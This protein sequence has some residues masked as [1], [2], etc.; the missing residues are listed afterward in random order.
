MSTATSADVRAP[1][2]PTISIRDRVRAVRGG[3]AWVPAPELLA[4]LVVAAVLDLWALDRN[5]WANTYYSATVRSMA[6]SWHNFFYNSF[7]ASGVMTVDKPPLALWVQA[8]SARAFGFSSWSMLVPQALMGV[9]T[10]ALAYDL[11]RRVFGRPA[12]F[13]AG[14]VLALTPITVAISRHN[15]PDALVVLCSTAALWFTVRALLDGRTSRLVWAGVMVGL[16]F[17]TKMGAALL[18]LPALAAA[19]LWVAPRGRLTAVRQL[20]TG[21]AAMAVVGLAWPVLMWLTPASSRPWISGTS[22]NSIWS[23]IL[24]YNGVGRLDGQ[25]GGPGGTAGGPGGG[26]GGGMGSVFGG[27]TGITRLVDASLGGQAGWLLGM[28]LAGGLAVAVLTRLRRGDARTGW[29]IAAGGAFL[30]TA[31]AF[32]YA[33]GIF[34]PYYVSML[35]PF[36]AVLI[37]ATAGTI[38]KAGITARIIAPVAIVGGLVTEVMVIHRGAADVE[39]LVPLAI[40]AGLGGAA[41]LAAQ[42]PAKVRGVAL[43]VAL[44]ALLI[45][46]ASWA[47]QT[48]GHATSSTFPA[49][50]PASQGM[51]G[52]GPGGMRGGPGGGGGVGGPG[53]GAPPQ[54]PGGTGSSSSGQVAPPAGFSLGGGSNTSNNAQGAGGPGA[55]GGGGMF[56][57]NANLTEALAYAKA[58]GG[59]TI[60]VSSQQGA[61]DAIIRSGSDV[62]ALGGFS[63]RESEVSATWLAQA[64]KDGRIR[65]VLTDGSGGGMGNDDRVGSSALMAVVQQ[66]GKETS[67]SGLYD[68]QGTAAAIAAAA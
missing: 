33:K 30:T 9:G 56:G 3:R 37:G 11:T 67:V 46:P 52:G 2:T 42:V 68:L 40:V 12:G 50:G 16:G 15:N 60:G 26:G 59:G 45:A 14:L 7:D 65:Y 8:L 39:G 62:A 10:V 51:S 66:V 27:D 25:A 63:G 5:G 18:V 1:R 17:E 54:L 36:T 48:L 34:H 58:N 13:V 22:D 44:G 38:L 32:S 64:V 41:V 55:A 4:L 19:Y 6:G 23:L 21:G 61:S 43:S 49:G 57:G 31:V 28:A 24:N 53:G 47:T 20:L 29:I 35:A